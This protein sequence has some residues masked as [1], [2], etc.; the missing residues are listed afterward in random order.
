M[1]DRVI[2]AEQTASTFEGGSREMA[3]NPREPW[4]NL[5]RLG[6]VTAARDAYVAG[7]DLH[8]HQHVVAAAVAGSWYRET[9]RDRFWVP[10]SDRDAELAE[11]AAFCARPQGSDYAWWQADAYAGKT[12]LMAHLVLAPPPKVRIASFFVTA[13]IAG[14]DDREAFIDNVLEQLAAWRQQ[15]VPAVTPKTAPA[16]LAGMIEETSAW[17]WDQGERLV[18]VVDGLEVDTG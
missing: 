11:L 15:P 2:T 1:E 18:P 6:Q 7:R 12:A 9:I 8:I 5:D 13:R 3:L 17:C 14:Q 10:L 16:V 4:V